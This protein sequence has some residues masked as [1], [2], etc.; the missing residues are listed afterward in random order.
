M[1][2]VV[3]DGNAELVTSGDYAA[4]PATN[5]VGE[6]VTDN[7]DGTV[8]V[9]GIV[10]DGGGDSFRFSGSVVGATLGGPGA[11]YVDGS[12]ID[13]KTAEVDRTVSVVGFGNSE[14][15]YEFSVD[16][17][18]VTDT[19]KNNTESEDVVDDSTASGTVVNDTDGYRFSGSVTD[20]TLDGDAAVYVDGKQVNPDKLGTT[21]SAA[22]PNKLVFDGL[23]GETV[24]YEFVVTGTVN[25]SPDIGSAEPDDTVDSG[26][27]SGSVSDDVDGYRFTGDL[28]ALDIDGAA[29]ITFDDTDG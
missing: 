6:M 21:D 20:F 7:D 28:Q 13:S 29:A 17:A 5:G 15:S 22:L 1:T 11:V 9:S 10:A 19:G 2:R 16:G 23:S 3:I 27:V 18:V 12:P 8:T 24:T 25:Q 26:T 14:T 4:S